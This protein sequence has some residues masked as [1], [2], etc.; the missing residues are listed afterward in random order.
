MLADKTVEFDHLLIVIDRRK[1]RIH[2][3]VEKP[4]GFSVFNAISCRLAH[5]HTKPFVAFV[6]P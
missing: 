1:E 5:G 4:V 6:L 2:D 3:P